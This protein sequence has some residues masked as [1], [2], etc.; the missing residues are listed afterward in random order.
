MKLSSQPS[1]KNV[2]SNQV[3]AFCFTYR[4]RQLT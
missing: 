1:H 2:K 4:T 3:S